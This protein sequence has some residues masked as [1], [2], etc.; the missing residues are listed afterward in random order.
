M[1]EEFGRV[2]AEFQR[3]QKASNTVIVDEVT[4]K[5]ISALESEL[6]FTIKASASADEK[7]TRLPLTAPTTRYASGGGIV[8]RTIKANLEAFDELSLELVEP[9][10]EPIAE[11]VN[12]NVVVVEIS[13]NDESAIAVKQAEEV[14]HQLQ[15]VMSTAL[16]ESDKIN[17]LIEEVRLKANSELGKVQKEIEKTK[18]DSLDEI[19]A[20][21]KEI[22]QLKDEAEIM[23]DMVKKARDEYRILKKARIVATI[24]AK[25]IIA[26][27]RK[28]EEVS[29]EYFNEN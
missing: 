1:L 29:R 25:K 14:R 12:D 18:L 6:E 11:P 27:V 2:E 20:L 15:S 23:R 19:K 24:N 21:V 4:Q 16:S 3:A 28:T 17:V 7:L 5:Q 10:E 9:I 26:L 22:V 13:N 8:S